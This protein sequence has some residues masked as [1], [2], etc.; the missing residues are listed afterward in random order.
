M[1]QRRAYLKML[2][3]MALMSPIHRSLK[4]Q[5]RLAERQLH[6]VHLDKNTLESGITDFANRYHVRIGL[7]SLPAGSGSTPIKL[8]LEGAG[9]A[10]VLEQLLANSGYRWRE[11][12]G[13]IDIEPYRSSRPDR[14]CGRAVSGHTRC[15][16]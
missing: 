11:A 2:A 6:D 15:A 10:Q 12:D 9:V 7:V 4:A 8:H 1:T 14:H 13:V 5:A 3:A 16:R